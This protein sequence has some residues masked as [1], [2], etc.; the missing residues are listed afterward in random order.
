MNV[1]DNRSKLSFCWGIECSVVTNLHLLYA[2]FLGYAPNHV[3]L[4]GTVW[5]DL[6][7]L[8]SM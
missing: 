8:Q 1:H 5:N 7:G 2:R 6:V 3:D 4:F